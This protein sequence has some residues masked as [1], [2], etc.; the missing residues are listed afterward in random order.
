MVKKPVSKEMLQKC[1]I[2]AYALVALSI[3]SCI[4]TSFGNYIKGDIQTVFDRVALFAVLPLVTAGIV[5]LCG[6]HIRV[7]SQRLKSGDFDTN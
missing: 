1:R 3:L 4:W 2:A 7:T 5:A 6:Y